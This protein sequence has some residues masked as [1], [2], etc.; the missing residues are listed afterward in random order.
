MESR[1]MK[2]RL[3]V[4]GAAA[5]ILPASAQTADKPAWLDR[6]F[7]VIRQSLSAKDLGKASHQC[8][9]VLTEFDKGKASVRLSLQIQDNAKAHP[10]ILDLC[11][12]I[13]ATAGVRDSRDSYAN[14]EVSHL[15]E[16]TNKAQA[17]L[18]SAR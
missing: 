3:V 17:L 10:V 8:A 11:S 7:E 5:V 13:E 6:Q 12:D 9:A 18:Q 14:M 4:F 15:L 16:A 1:P 2:L